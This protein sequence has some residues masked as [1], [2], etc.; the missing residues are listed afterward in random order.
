V[1]DVGKPYF[2]DRFGQKIIDMGDGDQAEL[3]SL[4]GHLD[5][6][7]VKRMQQLEY[8][9]DCCVHYLNTAK[10]PFPDREALNEA[11]GVLVIALDKA[12]YR[13]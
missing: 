13:L 1:S 11:L 10:T 7:I 6:D 3:R 4:R 8:V 5:T 2:V 9:I 12:G